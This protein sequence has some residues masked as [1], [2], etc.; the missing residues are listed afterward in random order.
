MAAHVHTDREKIILAAVS[1]ANANPNWLTSDRVE[2]LTGGHG[3][4][5]MPVVAACNVLATEMRRGIS[6]QVKFADAVHQPID[7][8]MAKAVQACKDGGADGANAALLSA[9]L[10]YLAGANAQ[11]GIPAGNRKLG[12]TA[13]MIAGV[14]RSGLAAVPTAKLNNKVFAFAAVSAV[15]D[16]MMKGE[17]S[18]VQGRDVP[19]NVG[20]GPLLGHGAL[21]EDIIFPAMAEKG[22]TVGTQAML[23]AMSGAGMPGQK[24]LAA[25]CGA[26]AILEIIH[27]HA[28]VADKYG[29]YGTVTTAFVAGQAA[30]RTAN[31]P[32]K[33]HVRITGKGI[34]TGKLIGDLGLILK[35]IGGPTV[36]GIMALDEIVS[37]FEES[38]AGSGAGPA[39]PLLG[40]VAGDA[41]IAFMCLLED[42]STEQAVA[43]ALR[44]RRFDTSFDPET[45]MVAMS[46]VARKATQIRNG[47]VTDALQLASAPVVAKVL[48]DRASHSYDQMLVGKTVAEVVK[49]FDDERQALV[50]ERG[51]RLISQKTGKNIK[52]HFTRIARGAR[53]QSK[54]AARWLAFDPALDVEVTIDDETKHLKEFVNKVIPEVAQGQDVD[55]APFI[56]VA[57]PLASE[58]LL[59]GNVIVNVTVPAAVAAA[60]GK[61]TPS[62]A[63]LEAQAGGIITAGIPG[64]KAKAEA[65]AEVAVQTLEQF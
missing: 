28:D 59:A 44:K 16:C 22:A 39:N 18:P 1:G 14:D 31:L 20:G 12:A 15:Y 43:K 33:L 55:R 36:I 8:L 63:G 47:P 62:D 29:P 56:T 13:R 32:E 3:M 25:L 19:M 58:L 23:D 6:P 65:A 9:V 34:E 17:L 21:G 4:L 5:N 51:S 49:G 61:V 54:M 53:R 40:H 38:I 37:I 45:A 48:Y 2:A 24:F 41:V 60:M 52:V 27:P 10:L 26:A 46:I 7:D 42:G 57:A 64:T 35:D 50:E 30:A 11:V